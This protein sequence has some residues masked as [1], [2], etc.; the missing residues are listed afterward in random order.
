MGLISL[1]T[2]LL[3]PFKKSWQAYF[4]CAESEKL[5]FKIWVVKNQNQNGRR[6]ILK[7][8]LIFINTRWPL[9]DSQV[10]YYAW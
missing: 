3:A 1:L 4:E 7:R 2:L 9:H 5:N 8:R 10:S 6:F